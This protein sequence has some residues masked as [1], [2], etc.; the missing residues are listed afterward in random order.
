MP[1]F[2]YVAPIIPTNVLLPSPNTDTYIRTWYLVHVTT[3]IGRYFYRNTW[4]PKMFGL[5]AHRCVRGPRVRQA[6][7][8]IDYLYLR[9][10][11]PTWP[12]NA[13]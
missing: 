2:R 9:K 8:G 4:P 6:L 7:S 12:A 5:I 11:E 10:M 1:K 3:R 13:N